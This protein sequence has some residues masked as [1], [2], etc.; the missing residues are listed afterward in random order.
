MSPPILLLRDIHLSF[1][2]SPLFEGSDLS[3]SERDRL[4]LVGRNGSGKSTLLKI[5]S[6]IIEPDSGERFFQPGKTLQYL[7]QEPKIKNSETVLSYI[8]DGLTPGEDFTQVHSLLEQLKL[9]GLEKLKNLSGGELRLCAIVKALAPKPDILLLDEPTNHLDLPTIEWL[10]HY[11]VSIRSAFVIISHDRFFLEKLSEGTIWLSQGKTERLEQNFCHFENWRDKI[12]NQEEIK[13]HQLDR[14][15]KAET[16]WLQKGVTA[17][18][19]RNQGRLRA[20]QNLRKKRR[21]LWQQAGRVVF[22]NA[23]GVLSG[24]IVV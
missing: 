19:K 22:S 5:A 9:S 20:L 4:C 3:V 15:I 11:L 8:Q 7:P 10:E 1:G 13:R 2:S 24:K 23:G 21:E 12:I 17:R 16:Q 14:K 18:R 6:G